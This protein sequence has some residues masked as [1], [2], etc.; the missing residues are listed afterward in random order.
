MSEE[1]EKPNILAGIYGIG[2]L[3]FTA[4]FYTSDGVWIAIGKSLIWPLYIAS[5]IF[6]MFA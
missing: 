6:E 3:G 4:L 2:V 5:Y 1:K